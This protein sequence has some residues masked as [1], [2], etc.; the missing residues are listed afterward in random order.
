MVISFWLLLFGND[1]KVSLS[2]LLGRCRCNNSK[3]LDRIDQR[4]GVN[5]PPSQTWCLHVIAPLAPGVLSLLQYFVRRT[6]LWF[7][8][9]Y[10]GGWNLFDFKKY[11][12]VQYVY[13]YSNCLS[14]QLYLSL[15]LLALAEMCQ[16]WIN[17]FRSPLIYLSTVLA[18]KYNMLVFS[19]DEEL[20]SALIESSF[21]LVSR[22]SAGAGRVGFEEGAPAA[23]RWKATQYK[24]YLVLC[25]TRQGTDGVSQ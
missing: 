23:Q 25:S 12:P 3:P 6:D 22:G 8:P 14:C 5:C 18:W 1:N 20:K 15:K 7:I 16:L 24:S 13:I 2:F 17:F 9:G 21:W 10:C 4:N 11:R 19:N